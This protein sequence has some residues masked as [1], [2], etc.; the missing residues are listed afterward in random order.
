ML[1]LYHHGTSVCAAKP[2]IALAEK[3]LEWTSHYI[4]I[5][6]GEQFKPDY[7]KLNPK[8]VVPTLIHDGKVIRESTLIGEYL[9]EVFPQVPLRPADPYDRLV[10]RTWAKR[11]DE[12]VFPAT[13]VV[14]F[15]ISHRH[16]VLANPPEVI[17]EYVNKLGPAEAPRRRAR[18]QRGIEDAEAAGALKVYDKF[19]GDMDEALSRG[20]W[21]AGGMFSL[22]EVGVIPFV[23]RLDM[24]QLSG[25]W[26]ERRPHLTAWWEKIKARPSF[27]PAMFK[28]V[29]PALRALMIEKGQ[30][31]WPKVQEIVRAA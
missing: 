14:T 19:L 1:E 9:D 11:I 25:L 24:L 21:L 6:T 5:L 12:E 7:L 2:R 17:E 30:E 15:A 4:D 23:N 8:G 18:L 28:F 3:G 16:P 26:T 22:A 27:Q 13:S 29:P 10:M 31:A 20:P